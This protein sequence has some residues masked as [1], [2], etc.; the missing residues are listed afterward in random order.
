[1]SDNS[2]IVIELQD[3]KAALRNLYNVMDTSY[4]LTHTVTC[5]TCQMTITGIDTDELP[6]LE[7][8]ANRRWRHIPACGWTCPKC[9]PIQIQNLR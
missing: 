9:P 8:I 4:D 6:F 2:D 1:M 3:I 7:R 5:V